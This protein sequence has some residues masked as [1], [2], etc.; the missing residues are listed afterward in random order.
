M[1]GQVVDEVG[2]RDREFGPT[3]RHVLRPYALYVRVQ[4]LADRPLFVQAGRI[5][6][7]FGA[8]ARQQYG[9]GNPLIGMPLAYHY[10]TVDACPTWCRRA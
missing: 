6:P 10:P 2:L 5:P 4:P 1:L 7:V 9:A 3:D 8:F